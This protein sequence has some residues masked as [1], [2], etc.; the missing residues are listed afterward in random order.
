VGGFYDVFGPNEPQG[1]PLAL[2]PK[3]KLSLTGTCRLPLGD[4]LGKIS[5]GATWTYTA[6][7]LVYGV[8]P[9]AFLP[10]THLLN[11]NASWESIYGWPLDLK[12]FMTNVTNLVYPT[13]IDNF[14]NPVG[15]GAAAYGF[16]AESFGPPRM[17]GFRVR[18]HF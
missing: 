9:Y 5:V 6:R 12:F 8:G 18:Y 11:L 10:A 7:E 4:R 17:F 14:A 13:Y 1:S 16:V 15:S 3:H 2:T